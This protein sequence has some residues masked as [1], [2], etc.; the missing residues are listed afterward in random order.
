[1][2]DSKKNPKIP[3]PDDFSKTTPNISF[4]EED[5][6]WSNSGAASA[7]ETP[8]DDWGKTVINYD[9]STEH[10]DEEDDKSFGEQQHPTPGTPKQPDWGMTQGNMN[11][12]DEFET[13]VKSTDVN[14]GATTPYFRLPEVD[15][16]KYQNIP[17]TA[18]EKAKEE[19]KKKKG[20][21]PVWFWGATAIM[22]LLA[23]SFIVFLG[24]WYF[25]LA[26]KGFEVVVIGA[27][28]GSRFK[29]D[30]KTW[31]FQSEGGRYRLPGLTAGKRLLEIVNPAS[32]CTPNPIQ[33]V[34]IEGKSVEQLV[35]C[36]DKVVANVDCEK[37][38]SVDERERCAEIA[39]DALG[40]P[41]DLDELLRALN[42]LI[43]N[44]ESGK[45][46]IPDARL[47]I[48]RK[49]A[50]KMQ[51]LP[52]TTVIE[53]GGH[54][55]NVGNDKNNQALSESRANA[56][57]K[58]LTGFGV[59]DESLTVKGYGESSPISNNSSAQGRFDNRRIGY[60]AVVR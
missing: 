7:P 33:V 40:D 49:A 8:A 5:S 13:P 34:G 21:I 23:F 36:R 53:I 24:I 46:D 54:T 58:T 51:L 48:L 60:R 59:R 47:R 43:I 39:I 31:G 26:E 35:S 50:G 44:F 19:E 18:S 17:P 38:R 41:P 14:E 3:P 45:S 10:E 12:D 16:E 20:G 9:V 29:V 27:K 4:D 6:D 11:L 57:K 52:R 1:V 28:P 32:E 55:D 56:V 37:T 30:G 15:R 25:F 42:I 22:T 2:S